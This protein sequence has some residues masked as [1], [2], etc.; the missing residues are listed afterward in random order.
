MAEEM[1]ISV[2]GFVEFL[3]RR[4]NIDNRHHGVPED[5]MQEGG[6]I[7]RLIQRRMGAEYQAEVSLRYTHMMEDYALVVEGRADGVI[8]TD[9]EVTIDE[10]KGT[11]RDLERMK[12]PVACLLYTSR[13]V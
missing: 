11:Y 13:C 5:A 8:D 10:I 1:R 7:H 12:E 4:G 9:K 3:L 2:R 6:R